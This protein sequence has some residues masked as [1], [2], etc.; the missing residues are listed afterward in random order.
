VRALEAGTDAP[1]LFQ[2]LSSL[3]QQFAKSARQAE[4]VSVLQLTSASRKQDRFHILPIGNVDKRRQTTPCNGR[5]QRLRAQV[6]GAT[7]GDGR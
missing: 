1:H 2:P 7:S 6:M 3:S 4:F 5:S